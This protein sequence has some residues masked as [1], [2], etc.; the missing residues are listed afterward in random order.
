[1]APQCTGSLSVPGFVVHHD[2]SWPPSCS[3]FL[4]G[5]HSAATA[6]DS[7]VGVRVMDWRRWFLGAA[8]LPS[9]ASS[10][11]LELLQGFSGAGEPVFLS[12]LGSPEGLFTVSN[13]VLA[14][15]GT[16]E[17]GVLVTCDGP[18]YLGPELSN[19]GLSAIVMPCFYAQNPVAHCSIRR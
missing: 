3:S 19:P 7:L 15:L 5:V 4:D 16:S 8:V 12:P 2:P 6:K 9:S 14:M 1:M 11:L 17:R 10:S 13:C 18:N